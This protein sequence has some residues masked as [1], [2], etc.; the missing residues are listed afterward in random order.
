MST[1]TT[2]LTCRPVGLDPLVGRHISLVR[3]HVAYIDFIYAT[4]QNDAF[5]AL[6]RL[7]QDRT[8]TKAQ[9]QE[10]VLEEQDLLPHSLK[11]IEWVILDTRQ[12]QRTPIGLAALADYQPGHQRAE[13]LL[14]LVDPKMRHG[15]ASL[16]ASLLVLDF[17][18]NQVG[19]HKLVSLVYGYNKNAQ[20]NTLHLGFQQEGVLRE[21]L[22]TRDGPIDLVQN[23]LLLAEFR[24]NQLLR[25]WSRHLLGR[26]ITL[27]P[28]LALSPVED[29][30][31]A[32]LKQAL[33]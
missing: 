25:R 17:A 33:Q 23:G 27:P 21:H 30:L 12:G 15:S 22:F 5:M 31:L 4:Y 7:A 24:Q 1:P 11:R 8:R 28:T 16:E 6:Y 18:F 13:L 2:V 10:S 14:G 26:D 20:R 3:L 29:D 9:V 19:L 32:Q